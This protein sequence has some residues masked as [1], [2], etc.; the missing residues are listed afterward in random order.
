MQSSTEL[1]ELTLETELEVLKDDVDLVL[2]LMELELLKQ[3][4]TIPDAGY[5]LV[6]R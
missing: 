4:I 3:S 6:R 5:P 1:D 2:L